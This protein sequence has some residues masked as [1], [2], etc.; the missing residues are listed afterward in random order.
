MTAYLLPESVSSQAQGDTGLESSKLLLLVDARPD[1]KDLSYFK[2]L[3]WR[4]TH[5]LVSERMKDIFT[6][7][8]GKGLIEHLNSSI[9][10][11]TVWESRYRKSLKKHVCPPSTCS[12]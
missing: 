6:I 12:D 10:P 9:N 8:W 2:I 4:S 3:I 5:D 7:Y 11:E 1:A